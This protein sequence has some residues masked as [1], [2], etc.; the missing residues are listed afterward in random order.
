MQVTLYE[1]NSFELQGRQL[2]VTTSKALPIQWV[3]PTSPTT[4]TPAWGTRC[5]EVFVY[6]K[7]FCQSQYQSQENTLM[8]SAIARGHSIKVAQ[9]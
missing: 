6:R 2:A 4:V 8:K 5:Y 9:G 3:V 1:R 7:Q